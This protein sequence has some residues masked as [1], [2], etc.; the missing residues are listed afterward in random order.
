M[1]KIDALLF[2]LIDLEEMAEQ[3]RLA[4]SPLPRHSSEFQG[5]CGNVERL[6]QCH[7]EHACQRIRSPADFEA[8]IFE[9][10]LILD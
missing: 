8:A 5:D 4:V 1:S 2:V 3:H 7:R 9:L 10:I 6:R